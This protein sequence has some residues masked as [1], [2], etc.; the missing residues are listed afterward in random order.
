MET[1]R[2]SW[3]LL[4]YWKIFDRWSFLKSFVRS[5]LRLW[6]AHLYIRKNEFHHSLNM[7][8]EALITMNTKQKD[9]YMKDLIQRRKIAH[10][11]GMNT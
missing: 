4:I 8:G 11:R 10:E 6:W 3:T 7:D 2:I 9:K 1:K 5:R